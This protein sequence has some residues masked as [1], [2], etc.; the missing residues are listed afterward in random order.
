MPEGHP[1]H[2][3]ILSWFVSYRR[4]SPQFHFSPSAFTLGSRY[5]SRWVEVP[6][7]STGSKEFSP[8]GTGVLG[9][10]LRGMCFFRILFQ[11]PNLLWKNFLNLNPLQ[12]RLFFVGSGKFCFVLNSWYIRLYFLIKSSLLS[13]RMDPSLYYFLNGT[14]SS[15]CLIFSTYFWTCIQSM[16]FRICT[17]REFASPHIFTA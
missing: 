5:L 15:I 17:T 1:G 8:S 2:K 7:L 6:S 10:Q 3:R 4:L 11:I 12:M 13:S 9:T 14:G 16:S